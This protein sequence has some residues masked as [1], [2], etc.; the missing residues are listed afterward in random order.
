MC[1]LFI[2]SSNRTVLLLLLLLLLLQNSWCLN[3]P[4]FNSFPTNIRGVY[5]CSAAASARLHLGTVVMGWLTH[6]PSSSSV[7]HKMITSRRILEFKVSKR[8]SQHED[9]HG[10][11]MDMFGLAGL[12]MAAILD[13]LMSIYQLFEELQGWNSKLNL[14]TPIYITGSHFGIMAAILD[15]FNVHIS[16]IWRAIGLKFGT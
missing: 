9:S 16:A 3:W 15:F 5:G 12:A 8:P 13:F 10:A 7:C 6:S 4:S 2:L 1:I 14:I 11:K